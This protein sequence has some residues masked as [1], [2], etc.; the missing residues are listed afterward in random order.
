MLR[1]H[2]THPR[3]CP[4]EPAHRT[5][6][7]PHRTHPRHCPPRTGAPLQCFV[8]IVLVRA[9][10]A[11]SAAFRE[12]APPYNA[13]SAPYPSRATVPREPARRTMLR[14]HRTRPRQLP[15]AVLPPRTGAP[16]SASSASYPSAPLPSSHTRSVFRGASAR[17]LSSASRRRSARP[18]HRAAFRYSAAFPAHMNR[19]ASMPC[20][21][22]RRT[23]VGRAHAAASS[24]G[25]SALRPV[26]R[27]APSGCARRARA[28]PS[29]TR[30]R[31]LCPVRRAVFSPRNAPIVPAFPAHI[32]RSRPRPRRLPGIGLPAPCA[33][34]CAIGMR[35]SG[36]RSHPGRVAAPCAPFAAAVFSAQRTH[37][38]AFPARIGRSR[39]PAFRRRRTARRRPSPFRARQPA[40]AFGHGEHQQQAD[41]PPR[42][43]GSPSGER[44]FA[45]G[46]PIAV[47]ESRAG[48][49]CER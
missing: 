7:R 48:V 49:A 33:A 17:R 19:V 18:F 43:G 40:G 5:M 14:P 22:S 35:A 30:R 2:R 24:P 9:T 27:L 38:A 15:P 44:Q 1:P 3:H 36:S 31:A 39:P 41:A 46:T 12:P 42:R 23:S 16:Y 4:R 25:W 13:S 21:P 8:R 47:A 11:R 28:P 26:R 34:A 20:R 6:L 10:A 37:R 45:H 32:D 29:G